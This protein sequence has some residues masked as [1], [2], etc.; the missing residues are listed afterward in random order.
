MR[1]RESTEA[2]GLGADVVSKFPLRIEQDRTE[3]A[4]NVLQGGNSGAA[5]A[6]DI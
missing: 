5:A 6:T 2:F 4:F 3:T 1:K